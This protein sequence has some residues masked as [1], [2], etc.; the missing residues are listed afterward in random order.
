MYVTC[1][2]HKATIL[3]HKYDGSTIC[4][5][6][7]KMDRWRGRVALVTGASAGIGASIAQTLVSKGLKVVACAR[8]LDKIQELA[9][10]GTKNEKNKND[11][12]TN[13]FHS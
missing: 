12:M 3:G 11:R 2:S 13:H 10:E 4:S 1:A 5:T 8:R 7:F 6:H 9:E